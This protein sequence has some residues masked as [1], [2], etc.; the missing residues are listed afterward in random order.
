MTL[1]DGSYHEMDSS[2]AAFRIAAA[3]AFLDAAKKAQPV[4]LEP[5]MNVVLIVP[6]EYLSRAEA[7]L[8]ARR[9]EFLGG[10]TSVEWPAVSARVPLAE[11]FGLQGDVRERTAGRGICHV[12]FSHYSPAAHA[13]DEGDRDAPVTWPK[14]PRTPPHVL[15]ASVPEPTGDFDDPDPPA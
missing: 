4:L 2:A 3:Q 7:I 6:N 8:S 9:G 15:R 14:N 12:R 13:D 1:Y 5:I 11:T 10:Q